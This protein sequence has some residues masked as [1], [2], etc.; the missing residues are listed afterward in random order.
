MFKKQSDRDSKSKGPS[1]QLRSY[2][3]GHTQSIQH[4]LEPSA[5]CWDEGQFR[6]GKILPIQRP[7]FPGAAMTPQAAEGVHHQFRLR[8]TWPGGQVYVRSSAVAYK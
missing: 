7:R 6:M 3:F 4:Y 2:S 8:S 5:T 1:W